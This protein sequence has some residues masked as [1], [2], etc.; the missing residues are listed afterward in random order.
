MIQLSA[1]YPTGTIS[2]NYVEEECY[3][4]LFSVASWEFQADTSGLAYVSFAVCENLDDQPF[5]LLSDCEGL[6]D[7]LK[8]NKGLNNLTLEH[9]LRVRK[10]VPFTAGVW[11]RYKLDNDQNIFVIDNGLGIAGSK[12]AYE[13]SIPG[14]VYD[15]LT[16]I[17]YDTVELYIA[18]LD[19]VRYYDTI[20][21]SDTIY[22]TRDFESSMDELP[23]EALKMVVR[24]DEI[25][26]NFVFDDAEVY[27]LTGQLM[28]KV[29]NT[30]TIPIPGILP[31]IY[32]LKA[33][34]NN[35][36]FQTKF[37]KE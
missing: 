13:G 31:G 22:V 2:M 20:R 6:S 5:Y 21:V 8:L 17:V 14:F 4:Y 10:K 28:I 3:V 24:N 26:A 37:Y 33:R 36:L 11:Q 1:Q 15:T 25:T 19:T 27:N 34:V 16:Y 7:T 18:I 29:I 35:R 9:K 30:N 32:I 12:P 23:P